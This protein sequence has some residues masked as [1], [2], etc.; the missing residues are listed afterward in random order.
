MNKRLQDLFL[1]SDSVV[2][3]KAGQPIFKEGETGDQMFVLIE[4]V[5]DVKVGDKVVGSFEPI[6]ILGEM[7]VIDPGPR[8]AS[9]VAQ[10]DCRVVSINQKRFTGMVQTRPEFALHIMRML[11]ERI[12]WMDEAARSHESKDANEIKK[13]QEQLQEL[14]E[15]VR[16]QAEQIEQLQGAG[17]PEPRQPLRAVGV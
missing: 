13:L 5:V 6:E 8:S 3:F 4:G 12:R 7:A 11:V 10:S 1:T 9:V 17:D 2:S 16:A 15:T 14:T